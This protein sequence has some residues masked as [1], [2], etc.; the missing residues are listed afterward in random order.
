MELSGS[1]IPLKMLEAINAARRILLLCHVSPDGD[2]VGS[3]L[4]LKLALNKMGKS[5]TVACAEKIPDML[6][7][8]A[9]AETICMPKAIAEE[10]F[11][12]L[13]AVD[14]S[15]LKRLGEL[16]ALFA[17]HHNTCQIDHHQTNPHYA[18]INAVDGD[19]C[20][21]GILAYDLVS[22]LN[23][24]PDMDM[25]RCFYTAISTDTGNFSFES[26]SAEAFSIM[27]D[28]MQYP[29]RVNA[30][31]RIL[32]RQR[33]RAQTMLLAR[34]LKSLTF[35][36]DNCVA[37]MTLSWKDFE[38]CDALPEHAE[39]VVNFG[40]DT[41]GIQ[42]AFLAKETQTGEVKFSL[43]ALPPANVALIAQSLGGGGHAL[44]AGCLMPGPLEEAKQKMLSLIEAQLME[45]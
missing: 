20:A 40:I 13:M 29:I 21:T 4:A 2:T 24:S 15:D 33:S 16:E 43:R 39:A 45:L 1:R 44:A 31:N 22:R 27:A 32:F 36:F 11:D 35:Y 41:I 26:T 8:L 42:V 9:G 12:L 7:F 6:L 18:H 25:A 14:V 28:L 5:I 30:M 23:V 38:K 34:A 17:K 37:G 10:T 19:A 3:A